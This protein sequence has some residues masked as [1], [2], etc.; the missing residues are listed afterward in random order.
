MA[1]T[2]AKKSFLKKL[3]A[4]FSDLAECEEVDI[5]ESYRL[6]NKKI[7]VHVGEYPFQVNLYGD[8]KSLHVYP[9]RLLNGNPA[10]TPSGSYII[11]DPDRYFSTI[12][13]FFRLQDGDKITLGSDD[14]RQRAFLDIPENPSG[15]QLSISNREGELVFKNHAPKTGSCIA[16]LLKDKKI[17]RVVDWRLAK[18]RSLREL[19]GGEIKPLDP[20]SALNLIR[21]VNLILEQ[22]AHRPKDK[23]GLPGGVVTLPSG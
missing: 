20:D 9:E 11:F 21:E 13:G 6:H 5:K 14:K 10:G 22:E 18:A 15:R 16:P 2:D 1:N 23:S 4:S 3:K 7:K 8:T 12:T 17:N 19:Y